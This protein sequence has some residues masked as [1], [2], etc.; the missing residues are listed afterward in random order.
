MFWKALSL[1]LVSVFCV[2]CNSLFAITRAHSTPLPGW[3]SPIDDLFLTLDDLPAGWQSKSA[4]PITKADPTINVNSRDW[5]QVGS[6]ISVYQ[7]IW[8]AST[9]ENAQT[10][11]VDRIENEFRTPQ[12]PVPSYRTFSEFTTPSEIS[13]RS[14]VADEFYVVCGWSDL[15]YCEVVAR[16][17]NYVTIL[18]MDAKSQCENKTAE[19]L[20]YSEIGK[21]IMAMDGHFEKFLTENPFDSF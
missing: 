20:S 3:D 5:Y 10:R 4:I 1:T 18:R 6:S 16:Y 8:R 2:S 11:Y 7:I 9:I 21:I 14:K 17:R 13:F 12:T 15:S 19:G